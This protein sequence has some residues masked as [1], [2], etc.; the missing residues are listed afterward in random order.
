MDEAAL[1]YQKALDLNPAFAEAHYNLGYCM[2]Q[3]GRVD[4]AIVQYQKTIELQPNLAQAYK[5]L[6]DAY[7][8]KGMEA[9][10]KV[11]YQ[12]ATELT[13]KSGS[14]APETSIVLEVSY[15][16]TERPLKL[17]AR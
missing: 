10:A 4:D 6:G 15:E 1:Q 14:S 11:A 17:P 16:E 13:G 5:S 12:K 9:E 8:R 7:H 2:F 3:Q